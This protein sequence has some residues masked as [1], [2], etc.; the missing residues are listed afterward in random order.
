[1]DCHVIISKKK[2]KSK[3]RVKS[4]YFQKRLCKNVF[5]C[6]YNEFNREEKDWG[7]QISA[8]DLVGET[9][10]SHKS[11]STE[12]RDYV[13]SRILQ[14]VEYEKEGEGGGEVRGQ[15]ENIIN[16]RPFS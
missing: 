8:C 6:N 11:Q 4:I 2:K 16:R 3:M 9:G 14:M 5:H 12:T 15:T 1:M 7:S 13:C 10:L